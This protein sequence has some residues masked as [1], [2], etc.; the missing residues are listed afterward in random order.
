[1]MERTK[2]LIAMNKEWQSFWHDKWEQG[3]IGFH[4]D[5]YHPALVNHGP[6]AIAHAAQRLHGTQQLR[7]LFPLCGKSLDM[8]W[9]YNYFRQENIPA[10]VVGVELSETAIASFKKEHCSFMD[11]SKSKSLALQ[12]HVADFFKSSELFPT[13]SEHFNFIFDRAALVALPSELRIPYVE[14]C[15]NIMRP[16]GVIL[17]VTFD[18]GENTTLGPPFSIPKQ[19]VESLYHFAQSIQHL[20]RR[21]MPAT[22]KK[23]TDEMITDIYED[24]YLIIL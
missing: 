12:L 13:A 20:E 7:A 9:L 23:F 3:D 19:Q 16:G 10:T 6:G 11:H 17:L 14:Q 2:K 8:K 4:K 22:S 15:R 24:D 21:V 1:M 5:E 18:Y